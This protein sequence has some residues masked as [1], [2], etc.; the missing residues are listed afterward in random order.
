[1]RT[2]QQIIKDAGGPTSVAKV[3][4]AEPG[5][6]KQWRRLDSIPGR[7]WVDLAAAG[8]ATMD[9]LGQAAKAKAQ[10]QGQAA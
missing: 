7:Y 5:T 4:N 8:L 6:V 9:E 2:H 10:T 1:M 3:A